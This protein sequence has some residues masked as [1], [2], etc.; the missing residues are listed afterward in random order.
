MTVGQLLAKL[1]DL[2]EDMEIQVLNEDRQDP[3]D[4][5]TLSLGCWE[6]PEMAAPVPGTFDDDREYWEN[7]PEFVQKDI[8]KI[9]V[10]VTW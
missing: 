1:K 6:Y 10:I 3:V 8:G 7:E 9:A 5:V 2:P 4:I